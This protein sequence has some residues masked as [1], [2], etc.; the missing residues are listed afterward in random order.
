MTKHFFYNLF[1]FEQIDN[2][3]A[4]EGQEVGG[5]CVTTFG[6]QWQQK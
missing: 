3:H 6:G 1:T 5:A 2:I 4:T